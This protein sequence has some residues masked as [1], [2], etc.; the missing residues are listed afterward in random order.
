[1]WSAN[2]HKLSGMLLSF[3]S[4]GFPF[5][6]FLEACNSFAISPEEVG[7]ADGR[8][9]P[10]VQRVLVGDEL[11]DDAKASIPYYYVRDGVLS[12]PHLL[13]LIEQGLRQGSSVS[14]QGNMTILPKVALGN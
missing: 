8:Q 12:L 1:M 2:L 13:C 14:V 6:P 11:A 9:E 10:L 4:F 3:F 7:F 5:L